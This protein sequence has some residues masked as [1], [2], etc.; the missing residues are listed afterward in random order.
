MRKIKDL[1]DAEIN[2]FSSAMTE[3]QCDATEKVIKVADEYGLDRDK[4]MK[5]FLTVMKVVTT[6]DSLENYGI[7]E[8][9][10]NENRS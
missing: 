4:V 7:S 10:A 9:E 6:L 3:I 8:E 1:S 2:S 5:H